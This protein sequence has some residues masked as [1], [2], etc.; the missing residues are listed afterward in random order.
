[1]SKDT[2]KTCISRSAMTHLRSHVQ[3]LL[4]QDVPPSHIR[5]IV[6]WCRVSAPNGRTWIGQL[7][8]ADVD[9]LNVYYF[10]ELSDKHT[11]SLDSVLKLPADQVS[12][13]TELMRGNA[14]DVVYTTIIVLVDDRDQE[15][16][17]DDVGE[18]TFPK[19]QALWFRGTLAETGVAAPFTLAAGILT[20]SQLSRE[21]SR[22]SSPVASP[23]H[24]GFPPPSDLVT[25]TQLQTELKRYAIDFE[26]REFT[27][28]IKARI[29]KAADDISQRLDSVDSEL[30]SEIVALK[31]RCVQAEH[32]L[33]E[34]RGKHKDLEAEIKL[35]KQQLA[36]LLRDKQQRAPVFSVESSRAPSAAA[37]GLLPEMHEAPTFPT[38]R[39]S[40]LGASLVGLINKKMEEA[41]SKK[42]AKVKQA[43]TDLRNDFFKQWDK[44]NAVVVTIRAE[45]ERRGGMD[46]ASQTSIDEQDEMLQQYVLAFH[47]MIRACDSDRDASQ[48]NSTIFA[49][50]KKLA[51]DSTATDP[52]SQDVTS[53]LE[54]VTARAVQHAQTQKAA[55]SVKKMTQ[56]ADGG[57]GGSPKK[58]GKKSGNDGGK[59]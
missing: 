45:A 4:N 44:R 35:M 50:A 56:P 38:S 49:A 33:E 3:Q 27:I 7:V 54:L 57:G 48:P 9:H 11:A 13:T 36:G 21:T 12:Y 39:T 31:Q 28:S 34:A 2:P 22:S 52:H 53:F 17:S 25:R 29:D 16:F 58:Q 24:G 6:Q 55:D 42:D 5:F 40:F 18:C 59:Q 23:A 51:S 15:A 14:D 10:A 1:M 30:A 8:D 47:S 26:F 32:G 37:E 46:D 43:F 20:P 41:C 19:E